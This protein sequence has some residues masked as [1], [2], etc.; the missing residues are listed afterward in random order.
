MRVHRVESQDPAILV[1]DVLEDGQR[2]LRG[3]HLLALAALGEVIVLVELLELRGYLHALQPV[4]RLGG[5]GGWANRLRLAR[6]RKLA[7]ALLVVLDAHDLRE[8]WILVLVDHQLGRGETH[9]SQHADDVLDEPVV[10]HRLGQLEMPEVPR[11]V[12]AVHPVRLARHRAV[13]RAHPRVAQAA[14]LGPALLV[15]LRRVDL[16][17]RHLPDLIRAE[18]AELHRL[19]APKLGGRVRE[20]IDHRHGE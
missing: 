9:A 16:A 12:R 3:D 15:G 17:H 1:A 14:A 4:L 20:P 11:R 19:D 7:Q 5:T 8:L 13:H 10:E 2:L 6:I 18:H